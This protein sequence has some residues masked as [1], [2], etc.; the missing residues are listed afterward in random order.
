MVSLM[1]TI[2]TLADLDREGFRVWANCTG[3][4][5]G[6]GRPLDIAALIR[7]FGGNH[8][9]INE[10]EITSRLRCECG[11]KG[12]VLHFRPPNKAD[13]A[14]SQGVPTLDY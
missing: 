1:K 6:R 9:I 8:S 13:H 5:C 2:S 4:H 11:H 10:T 14:M 12:G 7:R 3:E